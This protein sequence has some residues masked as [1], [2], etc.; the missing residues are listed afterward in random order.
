MMTM[1]WSVD[2]ALK[3]VYVTLLPSGIFYDWLRSQGKEG[4]QSKFPR[5][6][7]RGEGYFLA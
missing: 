1:P 4:G 6:L 2:N 7:E 5:G 3:E